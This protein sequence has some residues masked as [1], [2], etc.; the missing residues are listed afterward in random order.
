[1]I[2]SH[3][4][5]IHAVCPHCKD[6]IPG[7]AGGDACITI[8]GPLKNAATMAAPALSSVPSIASLL[9]P[10]LLSVFTKQVVETLVGIACAPARG[11]VVDLSSSTYATAAS[12]VRA[13]LFGHCSR[14]EALLE[15]T[16]RLELASQEIDVK[17]LSTSMEILKSQSSQSGSVYTETGQGALTYVWAKLGQAMGNAATRTIRVSTA[18]T[19]AASSTDLVATVRRPRSE[20][21]FY[22]MIHQFMRILHAVGLATFYVTS[23][24]FDD[25]VWN[26][27]SRLQEKWQVAHELMLCYF[28][29][30]EYDT[31]RNTTLANVYHQGWNDSLL[32]EARQNDMA[33]FPSRAEEESQET[34]ET[35]ESKETD[36]GTEPQP[37]PPSVM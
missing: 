33:F 14:D 29:R 17:K 16:T 13:S 19:K 35:K 11:A 8:A 12:V 30:V 24:F 10:E 22:H 3:V 28:R 5:S 37:L 36:Q 9:P 6:S 20:R 31:T 2:S 1:V 34:Y 26:T 21:E 25:V 4:H 18:S 32:A 23:Q 27:I 7:C 15:L